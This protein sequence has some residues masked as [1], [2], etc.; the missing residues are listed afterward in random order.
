MTRRP[1]ILFVVADGG[2]VR[3]VSLSRE[4]GDYHTIAD[5]ESGK[6]AGGRPRGA[7]FQRFGP[8]RSATESGGDGQAAHDA[9]FA[10]EVAAWAAALV[11]EHGFEGLA[12]VAPARFLAVLRAALPATARVVGEL[13]KDIT[14]ARDCDLAPWLGRIGV[15]SAPS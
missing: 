8:G 1:N 9:R 6:H 7:V 15:F 3:F 10:D 14:K 5:H 11:T 2:R 13:A 4:T 12:L